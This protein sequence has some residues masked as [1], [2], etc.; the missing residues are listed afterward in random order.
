MKGTIKSRISYWVNNKRGSGEIALILLLMILGLFF[1]TRFVFKIPFPFTDKIDNN[2]AVVE[3]KE[4]I[5]TE[6]N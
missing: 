4:P 1:L 6:G 2:T 5:T 3:G